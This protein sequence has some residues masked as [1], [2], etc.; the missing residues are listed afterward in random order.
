MRANIPEYSALVAPLTK[1]LD[2]AA[3]AAAS[4]KKTALAKVS[5][6]SI[7]WCEDHTI[8]FDRVKK[9]LEH[10]V[11][12][13]HPD[14]DKMVCLYTDASEGFWGAI[15]TQV[16]VEDLELAASEQR[17]EPLVFLSGAFR[18][19]SERWSIVEKEAFAVVKSCKRL[20]YLLIRP[21]GFRLFTD[22]RNL[23]YM[24]NPLGVSP[25]MAQYQAH[26][27]Q[28]WALTMTTFPY[29]VECVAGEENLRAD[30]L[31]RSGSPP[32]EA[33]PAKV[34]KLALVSPLQST[35]FKWP[36]MDE[37]TEVQLAHPECDSQAIWDD[38][39]KCYVTAASKIWMPDDAL[40]LQVRICVIAHAG[41]AGHRRIEATT[42]SVEEVFQWST[43]K[44]DVKSFVT[45]CLHCMVIDGE[46][47]HRP[48]GEALLATLPNE[49]I[50]FDCL[51]LPEAADGY[52][53][54][55]VIKDDLSGFVRLHASA[56]ALMEWFSM[57]GVV[58]T[59]VSDCGSHFQNQIVD[60]LRRMLGAH[61]QFV[62]PH[63]P[64]ANGTVEVVNR[65]I[66]R[67]NGQAYS[68]WYSQL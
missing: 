18:G 37:I 41:I 25:N 45:A 68:K 4:R 62:T 54:V 27:L 28:R 29:V 61:H 59:W 34:Y 60:T 38:E 43:M 44:A 10:M 24:F 42:A 2:I 12:L 16:P 23:V 32:R 58:K 9:T 53:Y 65:L 48:W 33:R 5:L 67:S 51:S 63:C 50:H 14:A 64:W 19:A 17:H 52:K 1:L 3:K 39:R 35:D 15:A 8:C 46:S 30:L 66:V 57:F 22:H 31:S 20:G 6:S 47:V 49:L 11:P 40:D 13:A 56:S 21:S 55:L 26:K 7:G 36:S